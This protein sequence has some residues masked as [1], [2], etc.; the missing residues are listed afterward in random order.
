VEIEMTVRRGPPLR[1]LV[2]EIEISAIG[3]AVGTAAVSAKSHGPSAAERQK[4]DV[5]AALA[6]AKSAAQISKSYLKQK[7][8]LKPG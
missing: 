3:L 4:P 6:R 2:P 5:A 7:Q 8:T 1:G